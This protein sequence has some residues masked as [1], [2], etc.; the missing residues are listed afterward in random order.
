MPPRTTPRRA[1][2]RTST[3]SNVLTVTIDGARFTIDRDAITSRHRIA[4]RNLT[5]HSLD[6]WSQMLVEGDSTGFAG[7]VA[8]ARIMG[9]EDPM[10]IDFGQLVDGL[11]GAEIDLEQSAVTSDP[12]ASGV[13]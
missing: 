2:A 10:T 3:A 11:D 13:S 1:Q 8:L 5:G 12:E 7:F 9:G 4:L 6:W